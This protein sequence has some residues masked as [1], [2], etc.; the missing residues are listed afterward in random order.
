MVRFAMTETT[1]RRATVNDASALAELRLAFQL[2]F[3]PVPDEARLRAQVRKYLRRRLPTEECVAWV[4]ESGGGVVASGVIVIYE[5][6]IR[7]GVGHEGY[8]QSM[9]TRPDHRR[10]GVAAAIVERMIEFAK[11]REIDLIL[12]ATDEGRPIYERAGFEPASGYMR[13]R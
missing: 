2:H 12:N 6:M 11:E 13:W 10:R 3:R 5:R 9:F 7:D 4:G 8:V 1:I